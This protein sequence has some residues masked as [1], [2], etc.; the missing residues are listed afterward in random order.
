MG[1]TIAVFCLLLALIG[2][3][4]AEQFYIGG[5]YKHMAAQT[6]ALIAEVEDYPD[7]GT[8][9]DQYLVQQVDDL[10]KYWTGREKKLC[11]IIRHVDILNISNALVYAQNFVH[12]DNKEE[13][14]AGLRQLAYLVDSYKTIYGFNGANI[15]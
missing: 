8:K 4:L 5:V 9:F 2:V 12:N 1:R 13:T 6:A 15:L 14:L 10:Q 7:E 3:A 11:I